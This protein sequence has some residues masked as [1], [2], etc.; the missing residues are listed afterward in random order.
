MSDVLAWVILAV[1]YIF[2]IVP[3]IFGTKYMSYHECLYIGLAVHFFIAVTVGVSV[4]VFMAIDKVF[5]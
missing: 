2:A 5:G 4:A 1:F 3:L